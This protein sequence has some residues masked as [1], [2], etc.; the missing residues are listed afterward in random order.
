MPWIISWLSRLQIETPVPYYSV[1]PRIKCGSS[2]PLMGIPSWWNGTGNK[3]SSPTRL[4]SNQRTCF[5]RPGDSMRQ[6]EQSVLILRGTQ[7]NGGTEGGGGGGNER[8]VF[9][10]YCWIR[11]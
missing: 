9:T 4:A 7:S 3:V 6:K 10:K 1:S 8:S 2:K 5:R 11:L